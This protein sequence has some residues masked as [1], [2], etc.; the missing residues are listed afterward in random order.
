MKYLANDKELVQLLIKDKRASGISVPI[1]FLHTMLNPIIETEPEQFTACPFLLV[2]PSDDKWT[3]ISLSRLFYD[4]LACD[5]ELQILEGAGHFPFEE[6][7]LVQLEKYCLK[8]I[9]KVIV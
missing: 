2:H 9:E 1:S 7:G 3:G 6:M 4:K 8:F 5:K